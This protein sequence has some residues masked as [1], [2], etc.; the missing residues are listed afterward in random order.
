[1]VI[2][3]EFILCWGAAATLIIIILVFCAVK[4]WLDPLREIPGPPG[5]PFLG[6]TL[7]IVL[8]TEVFETVIQRSRTYGPVWKESSLFG[9][10]LSLLE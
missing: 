3:S 4:W 5:L 7:D 8:D 10:P 9:K 1:M 2:P 6:N